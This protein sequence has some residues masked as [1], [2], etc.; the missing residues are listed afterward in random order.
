MDIYITEIDSGR[1]VTIPALPMEGVTA[2]AEGRFVTYEIMNK[3]PVNIP[4]GRNLEL[5]TWESFLPGEA[6][7][8]EPWVRTWTDPL[9]LDAI[10]REWREKQP[11]LKLVV[12]DSNI[13]IDCYITNYQGTPS[14]G[15]GDISYS[16]SFETRDEI[17]I[18][19]VTAK[20]A[21]K[22]TTSNRP[23][24]STGKTY[25]VKSGDCLWNIAKMSIHYGK[26]SQWKKIYDANKEIIEKEAQ[27]RGRKDSNKGWW[28]YPGTVLQIP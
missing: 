15:Y 8:T 20:T 12:T 10:F 22:S 21:N 14:G 26:G 23:T 27:R 28:I 5:V 17:V 2:G 19:A 1:K 7:R 16:I 25:K 3:G 11:K 24:K 18:K 6:R 9:E 4:D 13:N